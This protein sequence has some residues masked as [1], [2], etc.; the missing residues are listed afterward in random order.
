[1]R[2]PDRVN[3]Q[4]RTGQGGVPPPRPSPILF[5]RQQYKFLAESILRRGQTDADDD[6]QEEEEEEEDQKA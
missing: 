2:K 3:V 4:F 1:M 6:D 5:K